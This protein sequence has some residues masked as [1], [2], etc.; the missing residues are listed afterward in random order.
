MQRRSS[1]YWVRR[2]VWLLFVYGLLLFTVLLTALPFFWMVTT[3]LKERAAVHRI[4][5]Q[6]I[7][8]PALWQN[9]V[10]A[11]NSAPFGRYFFNSFF[12]ALTTTV[13]DVVTSIPAGYALA[14]MTFLG[15]GVILA[16][17]LGTLMIPG[18]MLLVPTF[19]LVNRIGWYNTYQVLIIPWTAGVFGIFLLRQFFKTVPD[20]LWDSARI[21]GC[22]RLRYMFQIAVPLIRPG[23][24]T[25]ALLKFVASWNAFLWVI[26]MTDKVELRTV[27][28]GLRFLQME[29][30]DYHHLL[31]AA[32]T[33]AIVPILV[34]FF[35]AQKQFIQGI[36]RTGLK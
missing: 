35:F 6:W 1:G 14:K 33:M 31:M 19:I 7:P 10:E 21:D 22:S 9:Y 17:L 13:G 34:L 30:G 23:I 25:V 18:Q 8:N 15:R 28:V 12:I 3:S 5:P 11:W 36:A 29:M 27:P 32:A 20:E 26:V 24:A 16:L 4:P 2:A